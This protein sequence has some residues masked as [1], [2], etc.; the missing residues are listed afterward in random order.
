MK[1]E[2]VE[3]RSVKAQDEVII[4]RQCCSVVVVTVVG[5]AVSLVV[6]GEDGVRIIYN[7]YADASI[8]KVVP[9]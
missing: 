7:D 5:E 2:W 6:E 3:L 9:I 8:Q 4:M 1:T